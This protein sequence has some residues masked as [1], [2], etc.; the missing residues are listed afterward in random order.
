MPIRKRSDSAAEMPAQPGSPFA[1][2]FGA[3]AGKIGAK[4][5]VLLGLSVFLGISIFA[6]FIRTAW[7]FWLL[8]FFTG[9]V[10]GGTQAL[11]LCPTRE[12]ADQV[13]KQLRKL[14][15][16]IPNLKLSILCGGMPL[17]PQLASLEHAPHV[18]VGMP[19]RIQE[20]LAKRALDV[21]VS[22]AARAESDFSHAAEFAVRLSRL[23]LERGLP[24]RTLLNVNVPPGKPNG[25]M[26]TVQGRREHEGTI[27][28]D[29]VPNQGTRFTLRFK[30]AAAP[31]AIEVRRAGS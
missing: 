1:F 12:L 8:A 21:A 19:G 6:S 30:M 24:E 13:G 23:V 31:P 9:L 5:G 16:A 14:A 22:L 7:H 3:L 29:S 2:L 11:V 17:G 4:R 26:V 18:V 27:L 15:F 25:V 20:L 10:Q 28:C